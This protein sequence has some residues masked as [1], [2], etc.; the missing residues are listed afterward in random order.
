MTK[1]NRKK[2]KLTNLVAVFKNIREK[3]IINRSERSMSWDFE[4]SSE[5][6]RNQ[7]LQDHIKFVS[8]KK[9]LLPLNSERHIYDLSNVVVLDLE[10][11]LDDR[12][13]WDILDDWT[14]ISH[15]K[16]HFEGCRL[17]SS[18]PNMWAIYFP[19]RG[20]FRFYKNEFSFPSTD[21]SGSWIFPFRIGSRVWFVGNNF[22]GS[23]IQ[24]RCITSTSDKED[25]EKTEEASRWLG[26]IAFISNKR[27]SELSIQDNYSS[28]EI[29]GMN[30]IHRLT[31]AIHIN[32]DAPRSTS[33]YLGPREKIDPS[34][35]NCLQHRSL[36]LAMR[37]LAAM[38]QD[39]RQLAVLDRQLERIEYFLNKGRD[40]LSVLEY[41]AW[42]EYWQDRTLYAWR[43]WSSDFY[44]SWL[45]P[46]TILVV[47]YL[48]INAVPALSVESFS[49]A[50]WIDLSLRPAT[51]LATYE[52][53]LA[54]ILA[55]VYETTPDSTKTTFKLLGLVQVLWVGIWGF[56]L[57]KSLRR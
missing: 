53:S 8:P 39:T 6:V 42:I 5:Y 19:W 54:R 30:R 33:I 55:D 28:I 15:A 48:L 35:H 44:R 43:R 32:E 41:R 25:S 16:L 9:N 26:S 50:H 23:N 3:S 56:A 12:N 38:N 57:A 51:E 37:Q 40:T 1:R 18:S 46:L 4:R 45:R 2:I 27:V 31:I 36:F 11:D 10:I 14:P 47:G 21:Y 29:T 34:F 24:T 52:A 20:T 49:I 13:A 22:T 17:C 7:G